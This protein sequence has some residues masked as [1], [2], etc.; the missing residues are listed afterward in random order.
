MIPETLKV[1]QEK[2]R[3][4]MQAIG[5]ESQRD[6]SVSKSASWARLS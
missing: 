4:T 3:Q 6:D 2:V 5:I 1:V